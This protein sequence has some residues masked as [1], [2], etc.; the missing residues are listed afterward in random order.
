MGRLDGDAIEFIEAA[1]AARRR[2]PLEYVAHHARIHLLRTVEY[3][4][5]DAESPRQ[6]LQSELIN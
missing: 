2:K 3:V 5:N 1:P 4:A 6:V